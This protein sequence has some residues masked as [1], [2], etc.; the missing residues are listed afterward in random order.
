MHYPKNLLF[1]GNSAT[2]VND[3]PATLVSLCRQRGIAITQKQIVKGG[4]RLKT[5]AE[6]PAVYAEIAKGYD[7]VFFQ[8]NGNAITTEE[9]RQKSLEGCKRMVEAAQKAG[10]Q[11]WFYVRPPYGNDLAG[12][13]S[14]DQ[15]ILFDRHFTPAAQQWNVQ[16][17]YIN[18]AFA[19]AIKDH[20]IPLWGP[21]NAHTGVQGA[22]LAVCTFYA[23]IF[24]RTA[25]E[26][27]TAYGIS[28]KAAAVLQKIADQIALEGIIPWET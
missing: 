6:E 13:R 19:A 22:Y 10:F 20:D 5:H 16:C 4:R 24:G 1:I 25:T 23:S 3:L 11:C 12:L 21:D 26:L 7:A 17:A 18:R 27:N 14:F 2:Y 15:C 9:E 28:Q 8:E